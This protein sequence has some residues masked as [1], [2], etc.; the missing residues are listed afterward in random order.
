[1]GATTRYYHLTNAANVGT[2]ITPGRW[3]TTVL[4]T[5]GHRWQPMEIYFEQARQA[6]APLAASRLDAVFLFETHETA[7]LFQEIQRP[8][9][10]L[11]EVELLGSPAHTHRG[12]VL[13]IHPSPDAVPWP[14]NAYAYWTSAGLHSTD[15]V[16]ELL[17]DTPVRVTDVLHPGGRPTT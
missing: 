3:G 11:V 7:I 6:Y 5:P 2:V 12:N 15:A 8:D 10:V 4:G 13:L 1:M 9:D 14:G 17:V 16:P